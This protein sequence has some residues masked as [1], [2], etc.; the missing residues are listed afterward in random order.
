MRNRSTVG[1]VIPA[2]NAASTIEATLA[3]VRGQTYPDL[4]I[5]VVDDGSTD[6]SREIVRSISQRDHR[7]RLVSQEN[8]GVAAARNTGAANTDAP[9]LSFVDAD[10]LW[11]P[12]KV[13]AQVRALRDA[14]G[15]A[16]CWTW[17]VNIDEAG[18]AD[19]PEAGQYDGS[20]DAFKALCT[21]DKIGNGSSLLMQKEV[22]DRAG[23]YDPSLR[24]NGAQGCEDYLFAMRA[25][26]QFPVCVVPRYLV[27]YRVTDSSMSANTLK[28][29][30]SKKLV[31]D[32]YR[33]KYPH[34]AAELDQNMRTTMHYLMYVAAQN[35]DLA[36]AL[37]FYRT[38]RASSSGPV[39]QHLLPLA[40][41][42]FVR[43]F[44]PKFLRRS[45]IASKSRFPYLAG[46][47]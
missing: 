43:K 16:L 38:I 27:G 2:Y 32:E 22:F 34:F 26:E 20:G 13:D 37:F 1:V 17:K 47:W 28:M 39:S 12:G 8:A 6:A 21:I 45:Q 36:S 46:S 41:T 42:L 25:V 4:E 40:R 10:D 5:V 11:A 9:Y 31:C 30:R 15:P 19:D 33:S 7:V 18:L 35:G 3:S 24:A 23:G 14:T 29:Y 44:V